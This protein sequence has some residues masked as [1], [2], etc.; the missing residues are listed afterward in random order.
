MLHLPTYEPVDW[1]SPG[2]GDIFLDVGAYTGWYAMQAARAVGPSGR[3]VALEPDP[4]NR[5]Q[6]ETNLSLNG[7]S[8]CTVLPVAA[9]SKAS[10]IG[11]QSNDV[12]VWRKVDEKQTTTL[13]RAVTV[14]SLI[15]DL[16]LPD[17]RWIKMDIEG[18]EI[19]ALQGAQ[20]V[21]RRVH[22]TLFIEVHETLEPVSRFLAGFGYS[23]EQSAFDVPPDR[24]GWILARR[25]R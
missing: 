13:V 11:W 5:S 7:F 3:V 18:A 10:E 8:N 24:H 2:L 19:E 17:V 6:L 16:D 23:I 20:A 4:S 9:W 12:S 1:V 21:L 15:D 25:K 14:D 22:P